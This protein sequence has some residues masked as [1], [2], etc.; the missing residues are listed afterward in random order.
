[1]QAYMKSTMP[2]LGIRRPAQTAAMKPVYRAHSFDSFDDLS[3]TLLEL[4]RTAEY[5]EERYAA[6]GLLR[7]KQHQHLLD[8]ASLPMLEELIVTGAWWDFVDELAS[9]AVGTVLH[10]DPSAT[11]AQMRKWS[12]GTDLWKR[13]TSILC[14]L[15]FKHDVD[16]VLLADC[17]E[18]SLDS[19]EF[20][21]R[22]AIGWALRE[23]AKTD[24]DWVCNYVDEHAD[25]LSGLSRREALKHIG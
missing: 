20:F 25:R 8:I 1:M 5:R 12:F 2:Y 13:R 23:V 14:Q 21:L 9:H 11:A 6:I 19:T 16:L 24:P 4:W 18:P 22:K 7:L 15:R 3:D 10:T 17:M